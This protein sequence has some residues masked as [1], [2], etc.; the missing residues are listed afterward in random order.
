MRQQ[1]NLYQDRLID[2]PEPLRAAQCVLVVALLCLLL[3]FVGGYDYW[4][5]SGTQ[6]QVEALRRQHDAAETRVAELAR[7]YPEVQPDA[8]L[9]KKITRLE[10]ALRQRRRALDYVSDQDAA[11]NVEILA[12]LEKLARHPYEGL[13]LRRL[14]MLHRGEDVELMGST[15]RPEQ[16]PD[17]LHFLGEKNIFGGKVFARLQVKRTREKEDLVEFTLESVRG[18][19]S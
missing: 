19:G 4:R 11:G 10:E 8:L 3:V 2:K 5:L 7:K 15:L 16:V 14:H 12:S 1:I 18:P 17:Y 13:W 6:R 9:K